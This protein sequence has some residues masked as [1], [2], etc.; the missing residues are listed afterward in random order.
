MI[1]KL[2]LKLAKANTEREKLKCS[3]I[4]G[5]SLVVISMLSLI[6]I[7][8]LPS[9]IGELVLYIWL[10]TFLLFAFRYTSAKPFLGAA[11]GGITT[12]GIGAILDNLFRRNDNAMMMGALI[13][14]IFYLAFLL[15]KNLIVGLYYLSKETY[16]YV[17]SK[18]QVE[19]EKTI[20]QAPVLATE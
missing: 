18:D 1:F 4:Y 2:I 13:G 15:A 8:A 3:V 7:N 12:I 14:T 16:R 9:G 20:E 5:W 17:K 19:L 10:I 6:M 11:A